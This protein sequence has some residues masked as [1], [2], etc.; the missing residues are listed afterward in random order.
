MG[1]KTLTTL[2]CLIFAL[3]NLNAQEKINLDDIRLDRSV[4]I[5]YGSRP[6]IKS[7][8]AGIA[9]ATDDISST[10]APMFS[11]F[12]I[13]KKKDAN[14]YVIRFQSWSTKKGIFESE[15]NHNK[16]L[17]KALTYNYLAP[18]G[19]Q[20]TFQGKSKID[21][22]TA[23]VVGLREEA[24]FTIS[25]ED[26]KNYAYVYKPKPK[27]EF[28]Y[29]TISYLARIRPKIGGVN[30]RWSTDLNLGLTAG[31]RKN[32]GKNIGLSLL[33]G[34]SITKVNLDSISTNGAIMTTSEKPALT[35]SL[36]LLF[37][38]QN[39]SIGFGIGKDWINADS[40]E[41]S[42]WIYNKKIFYSIGFGINIFR[43]SSN[44]NTT[45]RQDQ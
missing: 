11:T 20:N 33:G 36:N 38:Y 17:T 8:E 45:A 28:N 13:H 44:E 19:T 31:I 25:T 29:G 7:D 14:T 27:T 43:S 22:K 35:Y 5:F 3:N 6:I 37:S 9:L 34:L 40:K 32:Y 30:S 42:S 10:T 24:F 18:T 23:F 39:F 16:N 4:Y 12:T 1:Y 15:S 41:T 2:F 21:D 26:L